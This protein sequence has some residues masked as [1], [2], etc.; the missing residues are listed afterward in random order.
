MYNPFNPPMITEDVLKSTFFHRSKINFDFPD[1]E[2]LRE[3]KPDR[4]I[5]TTLGLW[6]T[7]D[8]DDVAD[9]GEHCYQVT[10]KPT[11]RVFNFGDNGARL[12]KDTFHEHGSV[13]AFLE[14]FKDFDFLFID[15]Y[16]QIVLNLDCI[17]FEK[18]KSDENPITD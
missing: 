12:F 6:T 10:L 13:E 5:K 9:F 3:P 15:R 4:H 1:M 2:K 8:E 18:V 16:E 14:S 11:T 7:L 17:N